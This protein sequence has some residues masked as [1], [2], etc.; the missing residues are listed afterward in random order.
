MK[1]LQ[2]AFEKFSHVK[3]PEAPSNPKL[4]EIFT[5]LVQY[6]SEIAGCIDKLTKKRA[7]E[8]SD[9]YF[10]EGLAIRLEAFILKSTDKD[11]I[12]IANQYL[13]YLKHLKQL[14]HVAKEYTR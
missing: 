14:I 4:E 9:L 8:S 11:D 7:V 3:F 6:D 5:D 10:D 12:K 2:A 13:E 1:N